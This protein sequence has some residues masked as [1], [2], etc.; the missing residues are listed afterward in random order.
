MQVLNTTIL[1]VCRNFQ[2][3]KIGS[4]DLLS[5]YNIVIIQQQQQKKQGFRTCEVRFLGF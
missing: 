3:H 2:E 5:W 1:L 4:A